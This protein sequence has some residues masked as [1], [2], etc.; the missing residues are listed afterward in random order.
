MRILI[1]QE[2]G[3]FVAQ[4]LEVGIFAQAENLELL[5]QRF[6]LTYLLNKDLAMA[7]PAPESVFAQWE[8]GKVSETD[9][10]VFGENVLGSPVDVRLLSA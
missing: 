2:E 10:V 6:C 9:N 1:T 8:K 5:A 7:K 4:G 3:Q